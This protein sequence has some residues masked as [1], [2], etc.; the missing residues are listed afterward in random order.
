LDLQKKGGG[1]VKVNKGRNGRRPKNRG[2]ELGARK[3][4]EDLK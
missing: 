4:K 1:N 3:W 2:L